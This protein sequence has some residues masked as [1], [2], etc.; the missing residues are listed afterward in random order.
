MTYGPFA[1]SY[2][3]LPT[4]N[5]EDA[6]G[7][8]A[9]LV[10]AEAAANGIPHSKCFVSMKTSTPDGGVDARIE[11]PVGVAGDLIAGGLTCI[12]VKSGN[13]PVNEASLKTLYENEAGNLLPRV[14]ECLDQNGQLVFALFGHDNPVPQPAKDIET[15]LLKLLRKRYSQ[16]TSPRVKVLRQSQLGSMIDAHLPIFLAVTNSPLQGLEPFQIWENNTEMKRDYQQDPVHSTRMNDL[17]VAMQDVTK[18]Q[19]VRI[20]G[21]PGVGKTRLVLEALRPSDLS[22]LVVYCSSPQPLISSGLIGHLKTSHGKFSVIFVVDECPAGEA[23][24]LWNQLQVMGARVKLITIYNEEDPRG[25]TTQLLTV[26]ELEEKS[27]EAILQFHGVPP[28]EVSRL[29]MLCEGSPRVAHVVGE[30]VASGEADILKVRDTTDVWNLYIKAAPGELPHTVLLFLSLFRRFGNKGSNEGEATE[31]LHLIQAKEPD[32]TEAKYRPI[33]QSL[34]KRKILQGEYTLY[35]TPRAL[36]VYLWKSWWETYSKPDWEAISKLSR[37]LQQ[38]YYS[39]FRYA[40]E[41]QAA[42]KVVDELLGPG[43]PFHGIQVIETEAGGLFFHA[44][45]EADPE[46]AVAALKRLLGPA[47][48]DELLSFRAGRRFV[49]PALE[50]AAIEPHLFAE[51]ARLL[52][53]LAENENEIWANNATGIFSGL[54]S[55]APGGVAPSGASPIERNQILREALRSN[56]LARIHV[57]LKALKAGLEAHHFVRTVGPEYRGLRKAATL[58]I[59]STMK[60]WAN[61]FVDTWKIGMEH[62]ANGPPATRLECCKILADGARGII[63]RFPSLAPM[64]VQ[65]LDAMA[66]ADEASRQA[67]LDDVLSI[68]HFDGKEMAPDVKANLET[69]EQKL[70]G[71]SFHDK[72]RRFVMM[73]PFTDNFDAEGNHLDFNQQAVPL[74]DLAN[75]AAK[76]PD[77]LKAELPWIMASPKFNAYVFGR[78]LASI[79]KGHLLPE[80]RG[81]LAKNPATELMFAGGYLFGLRRKDPQR[82]EQELDWVCNQPS[83]RGRAGKLTTLAGASERA[84]ERIID[85]ASTSDCDIGLLTQLSLADFADERFFSLLRRLNQF[86]PPEGAIAAL[87]LASMYFGDRKKKLIPADL[88]TEILELT[89]QSAETNDF[90][91]PVMHDYHWNELAKQVVEGGGRHAEKLGLMMLGALGQKGTLL[92]ST[93]SQS[94]EALNLWAAK[95]PQRA[96]HQIGPRLLDGRTRMQTVWWLS[97][98]FG[99]NDAGISPLVYFS[100]DLLLR[101]TDE[102]PKERAPIMADLVQVDLEPQALASKLL[103]K[104]GE[105]DD[106]RAHLSSNWGTGSFAGSMVNHE[107]AKRTRLTAWLSTATELNAIRWIKDEIRYSERQIEHARE[108]E[109]R[110]F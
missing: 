17:R 96:W 25:G 16:Y 89:L 70:T 19:H 26:P 34:A 105:S 24:N 52:L 21:A 101:W 66:S 60:E 5:P 61:G 88:A 11:A 98:R 72:L 54:F 79:D 1:G 13:F 69:L 81:A 83:L 20:T 97:H 68:L 46:A 109:E 100:D 106:V 71:S 78:E 15:R 55:N 73:Q 39:M 4:L 30:N 32:L 10:H 59:P 76:N 99:V 102:D 43:G 35:I 47:G 85:L 42:K 27:I 2:E 64:I 92:E 95:D 33:I 28:N 86:K 31:L 103:A 44:L 82:V 48:K 14:K 29:A 22:T 6:V 7:V 51:A 90:N 49:V 57:G 65:D 63:S 91:R 104:F 9:R 84:V 75:E 94:I 50:Q 40:E 53:R 38:A 93:F 62:A 56:E 3:V 74:I 67:I 45:A 36:H 12:Q 23:S 37:A 107:M 41:S 87:D 77:L 80:L 108:F 58:W 8:V 18:G 110:L